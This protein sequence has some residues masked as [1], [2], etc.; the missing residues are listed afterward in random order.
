MSFDFVRLEKMVR[1]GAGGEVQVELETLFPNG[2]PAV[3]AAMAVRK[4]GARC[5]KR[6]NPD[7]SYYY[8]CR[9]VLRAPFGKAFL[10]AVVWNISFMATRDG[11]ISRIIVTRAQSLA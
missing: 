11:D 1:N 5:E 4:A 8:S 10:G 7:G 6:S 9:R 2:S 3:E